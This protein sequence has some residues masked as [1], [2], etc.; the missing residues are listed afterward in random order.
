MVS[1]AKAIVCNKVIKFA[2]VANIS[3]PCYQVYSAVLT[4]LQCSSHKFTVQFSQV[5]SAVLTSLQWFGTCSAF[6]A[7]CVEYQSQRNLLQTCSLV[8]NRHFCR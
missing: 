4:S 2:S 6:S 7:M 3:G 1:S 8:I 5:Y